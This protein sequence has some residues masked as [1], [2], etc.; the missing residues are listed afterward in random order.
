VKERLTLYLK[1]QKVQKGVNDRLAELREKTKIE[2][3][4]E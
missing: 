1:G 2:K 3:M 4:A